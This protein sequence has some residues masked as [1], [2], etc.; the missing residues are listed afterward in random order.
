MLRSVATPNEASSSS[1]AQPGPAGE[2]ITPLRFS[3]LLGAFILA[4]YYKVLL[5][6]ETFVVRDF[7]FFAYPL[8]HYQGECFW[9]GELPLWNPYN[10]C[11]LPFLAQ[12]NVMALYPPALI[13]ILLPLKWSLGFFC[14][15]HLF[16]AGL[17]MFFLARRW[18]GNSTAG[19]LAG[20][21]FAFNGF[22]LNLLMW[23]SHI[24]TFSWVPW[25]IL[26]LESAWCEGGRKVAVAALVGALQMLAGGPET[27]LFTWL[28]AGS[29]LL[30]QCG[31]SFGARSGAPIG[32]F[33]LIVVLVAG[34][35]AVQLLPFLDLASHS[36]RHEGYADSRWAMPASGWA[37]FFVP[38]AFGSLTKSGLFFQD[39]QYWTSSYYLGLCV[40]VLALLGI[41]R[42]R[43]GWV[44]WLIGAGLVAYILGVG[45]SNFISH[46][47]RRAIPQ[48]SYV[49]YP[50]KFVAVLVFVIPLLAA[51]GL[52]H[53][54][55]IARDKNASRLSLVWGAGAVALLVVGVLVWASQSP[56]AG[57]NV[58]DTT[59][60]GIFRLVYLAA[61]CG[62]LFAMSRAGSPR[63]VPLLLFAMCWID[64]RTH[65]PQQNPSVPTWVYEPGLA[66]EKLAMNPQPTLGQSRVMVSPMA[67][68]GFLQFTTSDPINNFVVKRLGYFAD[69]NVLDVVPKVNGFF[70]I[71]PL[72]GGELNALLYLSTNTCSPGLADFMGVSHVTK[73]EQYVEWDERKTFLPVITAG[74]TPEFLADSPALG[75]MLRADF[76]PRKV[77][78]LPPEAKAL[79][80]GTNFSAGNITSPVVTAQRLSVDTE[81]AASMMVV[82]AQTYYHCWQA[83]VDGHPA[84]L[85]RANYAFQA[86]EVPAGKHRV[87]LRYHDRAFV[88]GLGLTVVALV[89]CLGIWWWPKRASKQT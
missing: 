40:M 31:Q 5:G 15:L 36:Q 60:N 77:V 21:V 1:P 19:A 55:E 52:T 72:E 51:A 85:L 74:Q 75:R 53:W 17:G 64:M 61:G 42:A 32:R 68:L 20:L 78:F 13:Y 67:E 8:A 83:E 44:R 82:L 12:W 87:V 6:M 57:E 34:L 28:L 30:V 86:V 37:N 70:S 26:A 49:T 62:V 89:A 3:L 45:D 38:M 10:N 16:W 27:I 63:W 47:L 23:P 59:H 56:V 41:G 2:L 76:D 43:I 73:P 25:V 58:S 24:A 39:G 80:H 18:T 54:Q 33:A 50:V 69:C 71:Y 79:L 22:S 48:L 46:A 65:E 88:K 66:R 29:L 11:G 84:P 7:G 81:G 9:R 35:A 4:A 14:L